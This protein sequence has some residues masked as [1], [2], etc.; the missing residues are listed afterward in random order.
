MDTG[1]PQTQP[2]PGPP[3]PLSGLVMACLERMDADGDD[4]LNQLCDEHPQHAAALRRRIDRLREIGLL[5]PAATR[6]GADA[7]AM[8]DSLGE[9]RLLRLLGRG[10]MGAVYLAEQPTLGRQVALKVVHPELLYQPG[11]RERFRREVEIVAGLQHPGI[12]PIHSVGE[13]GGIPY[14]AMELVNGC[15]LAEV[16]RE[17]QGRDP[18][19]LTGA[20]LARAIAAQ[21]GGDA[22]AAGGYIFAGSWEAACLRILA[23]V[24]DALEHAHQRSVVHRD[25]KP[26]NVMVTPAGRAMLLDFGLASTT[27]ASDLT[28]SGARLGSLN[29]MAPEQCRGEV[30]DLGPRTDVYALGV[31]MYEILTLQPAFPGDSAH[32]IAIQIE[33]G[34]F[35]PARRHHPGLSWE[36]ET[37]CQTAMAAEPPRR[38]SNAGD[39]A[40]DLLN[41]VDRRPIEAR[42]AGLGRRL[43]RW[44]QRRPGTAVAAA[45]AVIMVVGAPL[46]Y[47][48][49]ERDARRRIEEKQLRAQRNFDRATEAIDKMLTRVG[50][51]TLRFI[52]HLQ[53]VR[54][55]LLEDALALYQTFLEEDSDDPRVRAENAV[56]QHKTARVQRDLGAYSDADASVQA[57]MA[58]FARLAIDEPQVGLHHRRLAQARQEAAALLSETGHGEDAITML[59][60]AIAELQPHLQ[61][62]ASEDIELE[63]TLRYQLGNHL[64]DRGTV[65]ESDYQ[66]CLVLFNELIDRR[67]D[68]EGLR[69]RRGRVRS[70][71]GSRLG[72][73]GRWAE[74][75]PL[76]RA[77][78]EDSELLLEQHPEH[79][80]YA[81][82]LAGAC[83]NWSTA[84]VSTD[85]LVE[86]EAAC[87]RAAELWAVEAR[88]FPT[89][90]KLRSDRATALNRLARLL[91]KR[92]NLEEALAMHEQVVAELAPLIEANPTAWEH[93]LNLAMAHNQ[94]C[95]RY[96]AG[97][98]L[99]EARKNGEESA[100]L[101]RFLIQQ[102]PGSHDIRY[103][104]GGALNNLAMVLRD[105]GDPGGA[106]VALD[107]AIEMQRHVLGQNPKHARAR[108]YLRNHQDVMSRLAIKLGD[109]RR[110]RAAAEQLPALYPDDPEQWTRAAVVV[111]QCAWLVADDRALAPAERDAA[112]TADDRRALELIRGAIARGY[113]DVS[114][115]RVNPPFQRV[116]TLPEFEEVIAT[117]DG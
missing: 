91:A 98:Q 80:Q 72:V 41:V 116:W 32:Q 31:T 26:S 82:D 60:L 73:E 78:V 92:G 24:A 61:P 95:L 48:L 42:R 109:H 56:V 47:A 101:L 1:A 29:Y 62:N 75:E 7:A 19:E 70:A 111:A 27:G 8:P 84:L 114:F 71:L 63:A 21:T 11:T 22:D 64:S 14:F 51:E 117:I 28:R 100:G 17:L 58:H 113:T 65:A 9:F 102:Q 46:G 20:D 33:T 49:L 97:Q 81:R 59:R 112:A 12:V 87:S 16:C 115:L 36:A 99:E 77:A 66:R 10:G 67:P 110:A 39:V 5:G 6:D 93:R 89:M 52:P 74:G 107:E 106:F 86:A 34:D 15:T 54:R 104:L 2:Q 44:V 23:Q 13:A 88:D 30:N 103:H 4:A 76:L 45:L 57:A 68:D 43:R 55:Q 18:R 3:D 50:D 35:A 85:R 105:L 69:A 38:Y 37:V 53:N 40:R 108:A 83:Y 79:R 96:R 90:P 25:L 94:L